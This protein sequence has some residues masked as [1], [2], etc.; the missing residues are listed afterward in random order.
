MISGIEK[1]LARKKALSR[2]DSGTIKDPIA[3]YELDQIVSGLTE[4]PCDFYICR[5]QVNV[6]RLKRLGFEVSLREQNEYL[7]SVKEVSSGFFQENKRSIQ[8]KACIA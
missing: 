1:L 7:V 5:Y 8:E 3:N 6:G 4:N 2:F